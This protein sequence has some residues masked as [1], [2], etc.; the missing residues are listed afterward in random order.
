MRVVGGG[1]SR[2]I[3]TSLNILIMCIG[4]GSSRKQMALKLDEWGE[5]NEGNIYKGEGRVEGNQQGIVPLP[6]LATAGTVFIPRTF[7]PKRQQE[8]KITGVWR[9]P[10]IKSCGI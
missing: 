2:L 3:I 8:E 9:S 7:R 6:F 5:F 10:P 1:V 4:Q